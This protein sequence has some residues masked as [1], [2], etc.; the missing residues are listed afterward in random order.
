MNQ[1]INLNSEQEEAINIIKS[2]NDAHLLSGIN[3]IL[4]TIIFDKK[5]VNEIDSICFDLYREK[6][7]LELDLIK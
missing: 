4:K 1:N 6:E 2:C 3:S 5:R 7:I